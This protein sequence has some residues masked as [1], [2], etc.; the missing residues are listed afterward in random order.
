MQLKYISIIGLLTVFNCCC[1]SGDKRLRY[2]FVFEKKFIG[3]VRVVEDPS[4]PVDYNKEYVIKAHDGFVKVPR[5]SLT[6]SPPIFFDI[7]RIVDTAGHTLAVGDPREPGDYG[8]LGMSGRGG[9]GEPGGG[10]NT[11]FSF[12]IEP[13]DVASNYSGPFNPVRRT[14][15]FRFTIPA[16]FAGK[17]LMQEDPNIK[18]DFS[19]IYD[20][21][22]K[23]RMVKVP[24]KFLWGGGIGTTY[25][26]DV[27]EL[28]DSSGKIISHGANPPTGQIGVR[29]IISEKIKH[30]P[31]KF[32]FEIWDGKHVEVLR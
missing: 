28:K 27:V 22:V 5:G 3:Q 31:P 32:Y 11:Y 18:L 19:Q 14:V 10:D 8:Y 15:R 6:S 20:L 23:N 26:Y 29:G 9:P 2:C 4:L 25:E 17:I 16:G 30:D 21:T 7:T 1:D 13:K 12:G 24:S